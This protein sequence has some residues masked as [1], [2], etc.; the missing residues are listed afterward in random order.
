MLIVGSLVTTIMGNAIQT[1]DYPNTW[2]D[3]IMLLFSCL[4]LMKLGRSHRCANQMLKDF[5][6][7]L[8][9]GILFGVVY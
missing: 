6:N 7:L 2:S 9:V 8:F 1:T 5:K 4:H 3:F